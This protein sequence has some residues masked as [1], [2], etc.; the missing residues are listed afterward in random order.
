MNQ[1]KIDNFVFFTHTFLPYKYKHLMAQHSTA[2][3]TFIKFL[4]YFRNR[5]R[6]QFLTNSKST[7][8]QM[9]IAKPTPQL[10]TKPINFSSVPSSTPFNAMKSINLIKPPALLKSTH[11]HDVRRSSP[12]QH[13]VIRPSPHHHTEKSPFR[14]VEE[15]KPV[16]T[17]SNISQVWILP[18]TFYHFQ[19]STL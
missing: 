6:D 17:S 14:H 1:G 11:H 7:S 2:D 9:T 13:D 18:P 12:H 5:P 19:F 10:A 3:I 4:L 15:T 8:P 16:I